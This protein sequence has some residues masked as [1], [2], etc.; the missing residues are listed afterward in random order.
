M[1]EASTPRLVDDYNRHLDYLRVSITDRCNLRCIYCFPKG[2]I[3]K[4]NHDEVLRYEEILRIVTL[5]TR[6]GI[7]KVR[8]TGGEPLIRKGV[9]RFLEALNQIEGIRDLSLTTN[10]VFLKANAERI[11]AAGIQRINI[12]LDTLDRSKYKQITGYDLFDQVWE[13]I[14]TAQALGFDPIKIN[15]VALKGFN[16][17]EFADFARLTFTKPFHIRFIEYM[18]IGNP[19]LHVDQHILA[20][21]IEKQVRQ[22]AK[23][24]PLSKATNDG[25]AQRF[26]FE[27][28]QGEIGFIRPISQHFCETCNRLRL[29]AN[30]QLRPCLL[31]D[32]QEDLKGPLRQGC[33]DDALAAV[34][35][36]AVRHKR[37]QH[38]L[39][40]NPSYAVSDP[41]SGIGG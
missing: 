25:P 37:K 24:V 10:G 6:L 5:G 30:G 35:L 15:I 40:L 9:Y 41:M 17:D 38:H 4:V 27:G 13:G 31:S 7:T 28:S 36:R 20:P 14:E 2:M 8:I 34:F 19:Y 33:S 29:T 21:Q 3:P 23:L 16:E 18:P 1:A 39:A 26:R 12:S 32:H 11:R 22:I